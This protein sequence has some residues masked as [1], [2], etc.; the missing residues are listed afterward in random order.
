MHASA[1][2][3]SLVA[4]VSANEIAIP[5]HQAVKRAVEARQTGTSG[6]EVACL[7]ALQ[8]VYVSLPTP[9]PQLIEYALT[10]TIT[11]PCNL[12][13]PA[14]LSPVVSSYQSSVFSW[15]GQNGAAVSSALSQCPTFSSI[16]ASAGANICT[17]PAG[18]GAGAST[19]PGASSGAARPTGSIGGGSAA[20]NGTGPS[21]TGN[22]P[23]A[24]TPAQAGARGNVVAAGMAVV[25]FVGAV[26][27]L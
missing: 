5:G 22:P 3:I 7:S 17:Q 10:A 19:T 12:Q 4:A 6:G 23:A 1:V 14:T 20:G 16:A 24:T 18:A 8:S 25:G 27:L 2:L 15:L 13:V 21:G 11:D 26:A 9:P